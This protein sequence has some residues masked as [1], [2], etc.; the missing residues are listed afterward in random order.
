M[1]IQLDADQNPTL[2]VAVEL[3]PDASPSD[4]LTEDVAASIQRELERLNSEF[5]NYAPAERRR[6]R[7]RLLKHADAEYFPLGV[8]HRY[9]RA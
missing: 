1:Q 2:D 7:V 3:L 5:L 6:P 4:A 8:K 9:T